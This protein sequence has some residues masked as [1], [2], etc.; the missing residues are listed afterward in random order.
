MIFTA[1]TLCH[2]ATLILG[3]LCQY[4]LPAI[5]VHV[6]HWY[7]FKKIFLPFS[8]LYSHTF[9]KLFEPTN[10]SF[11]NLLFL[12]THTHTESSAT[13][14]Q[15]TGG[16][17]STTT[18]GPQESGVH[19]NTQ[20]HYY[21]YKWWARPSSKK[22]R[23]RCIC[24]H[25]KVATSASKSPPQSPRERK[26]FQEL[27]PLPLLYAFKNPQL[28][29]GIPQRQVRCSEGTLSPPAFPTTLL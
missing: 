5:L 2:A 28:F 20:H 27:I 8:G 29:I 16:K 12:Y 13:L 26:L 23:A 25:H 19:K 1:V 21:R 9:R 22:C 3:P 14:L 11:S 7:S 4:A 17:K 18:A 24:S 10:V 6:K 15:I